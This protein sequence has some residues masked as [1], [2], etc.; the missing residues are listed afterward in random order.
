MS[1]ERDIEYL[2]DVPIL[3]DFGDEQL[4]L[5]AF[6]SE[7]RE[8]ERGTRLFDAGERADCGYL[9]TSGE[10]VL[11]DGTHRT[12]EHCGPGTLIGERAILME[13]VRPARAIASRD[14]SVIQ[15][16]RV[17]FHRILNEYPD[18]AA[19]LQVRLKRRITDLVD[20]MGKIRPLLSKDRPKNYR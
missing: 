11:G 20:E 9:V 4:R 18:V 1:L 12:K 13:T 5:I 10:I 7:R 14:S 2:A 8:I 15:I 19:K 3:Q 17:L 6:G 16:R